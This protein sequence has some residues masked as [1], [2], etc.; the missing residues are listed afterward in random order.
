ME[1]KMICRNPVR[2]SLKTF[3]PA[4][5]LLLCCSI[6]AF[7]QAPSEPQESG[8]KDLIKAVFNSPVKSA[9]STLGRQMGLNIVF[10]DA[11]KN[12]RLTIELNDV[13]IEQV[14]KTIFEEKKL[15]ARIIE[16]KTI[17]IFPDNE[18][19]RR[20]YEQ[21]ERWPAKSDGNK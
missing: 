2:K 21:Y 16:E 12:D 10:D 14:L 7:A 5:F 1:V 19:N 18:T 17:I 8:K 20:F 4:L 13:T 9:I 3:A 11:V 15:Q 6:S